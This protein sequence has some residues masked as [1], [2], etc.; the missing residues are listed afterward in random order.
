MKWGV[1]SARPKNAI[2][3]PADSDPALQREIE[4]LRH[5]GERVV[6]QLSG[7]TGTAKDLDCDRQIISR[8]GQW[9]VEKLK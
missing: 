9:I 3:A 7:Q 2:F 5:R 4:T 6:V 8:G 1:T